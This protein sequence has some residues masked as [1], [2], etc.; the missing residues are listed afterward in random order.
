MPR[1]G[2]KLSP[3]A[4][5]RQAEAIRN[6]QKE[7]TSIINIR[8]RKEKHEVYRQMAQRIGKPLATIIREYLDSI[9]EE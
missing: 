4:A 3:E 9:C 5:A 6:W 8:V 7:N 1:K 2:V